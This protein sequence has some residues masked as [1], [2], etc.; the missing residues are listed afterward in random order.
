MLADGPALTGEIRSAVRGAG[1]SR[2]TLDRTKAHLCIESKRRSFGRDAV[3]TGS[4]RSAA[5][6]TAGR[7][8]TDLTPPPSGG[9]S[10]AEPAA[11]PDERS[12]RAG[13]ADSVTDEDR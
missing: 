3:S 4:L 6:A 11:G 1:G 10:R 5:R 9:R 12:G 7:T 8:P 2:G 13:R